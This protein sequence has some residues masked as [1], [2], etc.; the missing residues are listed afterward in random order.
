[1]NQMASYSYDLLG[2]GTQINYTGGGSDSWGYTRDG[3]TASKNMETLSYDKIGN[4]TQWNSNG[5][6]G[7]VSYSYVGTHGSKAL[8]LPSASTGTGNIGSYAYTYNTKYLLHTMADTSKIAQSYTYSYSSAKQITGLLYPNQTSTGYVYDNKQLDSIQVQQL[9]VSPPINWLATDS[10][11]NSDGQRTAYSFSVTN[12]QG[13]SFAENH[14]F[15]YD[16][17]GRTASM[18]YQ[19][20]QRTVDFSYNASTG[21]INELDY[22]DLGTY[23]LSHDT[24]GRL[25]SVTYPNFQQES[26]TYQGGL[27]RLSQIQYPNNQSLG[28]SW[29]GQGQI[30]QLQANDNGTPTNF[31]FS[32]NTRGKLASYTKTEGGITTEQW[33]L[34]HG[35]QGLEK[36]QRLQYGMLNL[37]LDFTTDP[38]GNILSMTHTPSGGAQGYTGEVYFH[39]DNAGNTSLLTNASGAPLASFQHDALSGMLLNE[40][41]PQ[42]ITVINANSKGDIK[43]QIMARVVILNHVIIIPGFTPILIDAEDRIV[44]WDPPKGERSQEYIDC[45]CDCNPEERAGDNVDKNTRWFQETQAWFNH[46]FNSS[47]ETL[48]NDRF[49]PEYPGDGDGRIGTSPS[50]KPIYTASSAYDVYKRQYEEGKKWKDYKELNPWDDDDWDKWLKEKYPNNDH[51]EDGQGCLTGRGLAGILQTSDCMLECCHLYVWFTK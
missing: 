48:Y 5:M 12:G 49:G 34:F 10:T 50:G 21:L 40:W 2:R 7:A 44:R 41:N 38:R 15:S 18:T 22:S 24:V 28:F 29:N 3:R 23:T 14:G 42:N 43:I 46:H 31:A 26:Y 17:A 1:L 37:T 39:Y 9:N 35:P 20:A 19:N 30:S 16:T 47:C 32:Y 27:G 45:I 6:D 11:Y 8:G 4:I 36:A 13:G 51:G 25:N 33:Y